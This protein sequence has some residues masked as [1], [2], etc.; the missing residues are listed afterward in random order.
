[1]NG[2]AHPQLRAK[3]HAKYGSKWRV[4][5]R[6][7]SRNRI[8]HVPLLIFGKEWTIKRKRKKDVQT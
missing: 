3:T 6:R 7:A 2:M 4:D 5:V 1:M 8:S